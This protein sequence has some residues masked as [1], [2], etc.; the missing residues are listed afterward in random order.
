MALIGCG[1]L[2]ALGDTMRRACLPW[3]WT[4]GADHICRLAEKR[5][6]RGLDVGDRCKRSG[7]G[8][9]DGCIRQ[10]RLVCFVG[11]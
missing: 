11:H 4:V 3:E 10:L 1:A 5:K 6:E 2:S 8:R 7:R 9:G